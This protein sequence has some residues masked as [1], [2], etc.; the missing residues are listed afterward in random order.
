MAANFFQ[1][2]QGDQSEE[3]THCFGTLNRQ[4]PSR[5]YYVVMRKE[6]KNLS[7]YLLPDVSKQSKMKLRKH[8]IRFSS[9]YIG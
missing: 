9:D 6:N 3:L 5:A 2:L 1:F 7:P 8:K 4:F